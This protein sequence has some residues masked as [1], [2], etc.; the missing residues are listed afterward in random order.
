LAEGRHVEGVWSFDQ[1]IVDDGGPTSGDEQGQILDGLGFEPG[2][3]HEVDQRLVERAED[4]VDTTATRC[5]T[6]LSMADQ[7]CFAS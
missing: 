5:R 2:G 3:G 4:A 6:Q 1:P 7:S